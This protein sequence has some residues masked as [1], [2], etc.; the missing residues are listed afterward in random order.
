MNMCSEVY[1]AAFQCLVYFHP[2]KSD[3]KKKITVCC[4]Y[5]FFR[6][7]SSADSY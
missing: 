6:L 4:K 2:M 7:L 5:K 3:V 1:S